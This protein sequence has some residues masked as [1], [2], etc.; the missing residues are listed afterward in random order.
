MDQRSWRVWKAMTFPRRVRAEIDEGSISVS[1]IGDSR[2][3]A[4]AGA[5]G[6]G[7]RKQLRGTGYKPQV[8]YVISGLSAMKPDLLVLP[9]DTTEIEH[10]EG[11]GV[12]ASGVPLV[13]EIVGFSSWRERELKP[14]FYAGAGIPVYVIVDDSDHGGAVT[15][16]ARP[17]PGRRA[18]DF[19]FRYP[20]GK[21]A[22][23]PE[24]PAEGCVI[25]PEITGVRSV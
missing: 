2:H 14:G 24:G 9:E 13:V 12:L 5:L 20:Y 15:V 7:L 1:L 19:S 10:P 17:D 11:V 25:G 22:V 23:I 18:Y 16:L 3:M 6:R 8:R 4:V 21:N